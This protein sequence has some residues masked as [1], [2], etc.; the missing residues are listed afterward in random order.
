MLTRGRPVRD[1]YWT[2]S[3][4]CLKSIKIIRNCRFWSKLLSGICFN[5]ID[6][7]SILAKH[8]LVVVC[9]LNLFNRLSIIIANTLY[10]TSSR[11]V[12]FELEAFFSSLAFSLFS[13]RFTSNDAP[14]FEAFFLILSVFSILFYYFRRL[15]SFQYF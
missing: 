4:A 14:Y 3:H 2:E 5:L 13:I 7:L 10:T 15:F 12:M 9:R 8:A 11:N 6:C 1:L